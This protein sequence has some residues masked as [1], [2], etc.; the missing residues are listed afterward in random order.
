MSE[1]AI[2]SDFYLK[3]ALRCSGAV[4]RRSR[5]ALRPENGQGTVEYVGAV[6]AAAIIVLLLL[7]AAGTIGGDLTRSVKAKISEIV[8]YGE[9]KTETTPSGEQ[10]GG[11]ESG[12]QQDG[13]QTGEDPD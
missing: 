8:G 1:L 12:G 6:I 3:E 2:K 9:R 7:G 11:E 5:E 4:L 13:G 10:D